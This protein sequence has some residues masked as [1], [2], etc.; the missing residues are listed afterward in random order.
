MIKSDARRL[1]HAGPYPL[2]ATYV[3]DVPIGMTL[4]Q[5]GA[6][7]LSHGHW[8][9]G[10]FWEGQDA[11]EIRRITAEYDDSTFLDFQLFALSPNDEP[12]FALAVE[13]TTAVRNYGVPYLVLTLYLIRDALHRRTRRGKNVNRL[14]VLYSQAVKA[15]RAKACRDDRYPH[16]AEWDR[17]TGRAPRLADCSCSGPVS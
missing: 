5:I 14:G 16:G 12:D 2:G 15:M 6:E 3:A 4:K 10:G 13:R 1:Y 9:V 17:D 11:E 7:L 8:V